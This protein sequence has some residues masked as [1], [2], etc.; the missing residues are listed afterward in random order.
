MCGIEI[1]TKGWYYLRSLSCSCKAGAA[2]YQHSLGPCYRRF[3]LSQVPIM[4][5]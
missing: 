5:I 2:S 1:G 3:V 4:L